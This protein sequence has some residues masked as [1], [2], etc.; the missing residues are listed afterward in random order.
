MPNLP[1]TILIAGGLFH[2]GFAVFHLS[3]WKLFRWKEDL[4]SLSRINR[5]VMQILNLCLTYVFVVVGVV[6]IV[7]RREMV[8]TGLGRGL[9]VAIAVFWFLRL[10][11]QIIF[12]GL[13]GRR[14][15]IFSVLC[16]IGG[17]VYLL[18]LWV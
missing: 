5:A 18:P 16:F 17:L 3:F 13:R 4:A 6:S 7:Y 15:S 9:L 11:E 8:S 10:V 14:T 12:F 1:E 2:L